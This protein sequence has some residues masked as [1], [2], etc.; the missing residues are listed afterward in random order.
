M[1]LLDLMRNTIERIKGYAQRA[2]PTA[3]DVRKA[4]ETQMEVAKRLY[5]HL[6]AAVRPVTYAVQ[7]AL[8]VVGLGLT[9]SRKTG[10]ELVKEGLLTPTAEKVAGIS[11]LVAGSLIPY[12]TAS[13]VLEATGAAKLAAQSLAGKAL[14]YGLEGA[15]GGAWVEASRAAEEGGPVSQGVVSGAIGGAFW[16]AVPT[17]VAG[18]AMKGLS[19]LPSFFERGSPEKRQVSTVF[20]Q[21]LRDLAAA[22]NRGGLRWSSAIYEAAKGHEPLL[23]ALTLARAWLPD[24]QFLDPTAWKSLLPQRL[25]QVEQKALAGGNAEAASF[26]K[27]LR[28]QI[29]VAPDEL[30]AR[31]AQTAKPLFDQ[32][33][34]LARTLAKA[35][36]VNLWE[37]PGERYVPLFITEQGLVKRGIQPSSQ[38]VALQHTRRPVR[39]SV[40]FLPRGH[41]LEDALAKFGEDLVLDADW[42]FPFHHSELRRVLANVRFLNRLRAI[43]ARTP[44]ERREVPVDLPGQ[45][46]EDLKRTLTGIA[47]A[48]VSALG[49]KVEAGSPELRALGVLEPLLQKR[50]LPKATIERAARHLQGSPLAQDLLNALQVRGAKR[51]QAVEQV[52]NAL[53]QAV[54]RPQAAPAELAEHVARIQD[55]LNRLRSERLAL[56]ADAQKWLSDRL[57]QMFR[58]QG[59]LERAFYNLARTATRIKVLQPFD[60]VTQMVWTVGARGSWGETVS[61]VHR[62]ASGLR[63]LQEG[64]AAL[65]GVAPELDALLEAGLDI[66]GQAWKRE[67]FEHLRRPLQSAAGRASGFVERLSRPFEDIAFGPTVHMRVGLALDLMRRW[68]PVLGR[69][70]AAKAAASVA[71]FLTGQVSMELLHPWAQWLLRMFALAPK[72]LTHTMQ[73]PLRAVGQV[74]EA[75]L[76]AAARELVQDF[77]ADYLMRT[78]YSQLILA[79]MLNRRIN[80]GRNIWE[81][82]PGRRHLVDITPLVG[83]GPRGERQYFDPW[84]WERDYPRLIQYVAQ[85]NPLRYFEY[86]IG[87]LQAVV[88]DLLGYDVAR[89]QRIPS[90]WG[91]RF[92]AAALDL[93]DTL[94]PAGTY[95][96]PGA[97]INRFG[98]WSGTPTGRF[99]PVRWNM[100]LFGLRFT[101]GRPATSE[102]EMQRRVVEAIRHGLVG[103][104]TD[105][106]GALQ[107]APTRTP[108]GEML[109][110]IYGKVPG[111]ADTE[112]SAEILGLPT[113]QRLKAIANIFSPESQALFQKYLGVPATPK[114]LW[115]MH[116]IFAQDNPAD[117]EMLLQR[118]TSRV[119]IEDLRRRLNRAPTVGDLIKYHRTLLYRD[120]PPDQ[121]LGEGAKARKYLELSRRR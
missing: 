40:H 71:N 94:L 8:D 120:L 101:P 103:F 34:S 78:V 73:L 83:L 82:E 121:T 32:S 76:S 113:E 61:P 90:D 38:A 6:P 112:R 16:G 69:Q 77:L 119:A 25:T 52:V 74:A 27:V 100:E 50:T 30:I 70:E 33:E 92:K 118:L 47:Q 58:R 31:L 66:G 106:Q 72:W 48:Q 55:W 99:D 22:V 36:L 110:R 42:V 45:L 109:A 105:R 14:R 86:K 81:N 28:K 88:L 26:A 98:G 59:E 44:E 97:G 18:G 39:M 93:A 43:V 7:R 29:Q 63:A 116:L 20:T 96:L 17:Y 117:R 60:W 84:F 24:E 107:M 89:G 57:Y 21:W 79:N 41:T 85:G 80:N 115:E 64:R 46:Q 62:L 35:G 51:R 2:L 54:Q 11:G 13:K 37:H 102:Q 56:P 87:P 65:K 95:S 23:K 114:A 67:A 1:A 15:L 53:R 68:E 12:G 5:A 19:R 111:T 3:E 104:R 108:E 49:R 10:E 9:R 4:E 75:D 91:E